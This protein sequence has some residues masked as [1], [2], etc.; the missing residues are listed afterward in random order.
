MGFC[1]G[2]E[3]Y[4][5]HLA[6]RDA[7]EPP[8]T[9]LDYFGMMGKRDWL[10]IVDESHM[11]LPQLSSMYIGDRERKLKLVKHGY[12]LPS[13]LDNRPL[14]DEEFWKR[15]HQAVF[16]SATP[17]ELELSLADRKPVDMI[18]RPTFLCDPQIEVR[19]SKFRFQDFLA[20]VKQRAEIGER[21][22]AVAISQRDAESMSE[23]LIENDVKSK[24]IH[25]EMTAHKRTEALNE[26]QNGT[27]DCLVGV[28]LLREGLDLPQVSF[29]AIFSADRKGF[30]RSEAAIMQAIGRAARHVD[31]KAI[32]YAEATNY[33]IQNCI[34][35]TNR[36]RTLQTDYNKHHGQTP[37]SAQGNSTMSNSDLAIKGD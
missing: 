1:D 16:V 29:V 17:S 11:A 20:E 13:A 31:G 23:F 5:R 10:L 22:L 9:L 36:R 25:C 34:E 8:D 7:G 19:S 21:T 6:Q 12:R 30:L 27:I 28:N 24:Y 37:Q 4:S 3:N 14:K 32:L 15:I 18:I 35:E 2:M 26:L 33:T